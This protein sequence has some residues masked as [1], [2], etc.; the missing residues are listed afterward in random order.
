MQICDITLYVYQVVHRYVWRN[1]AI[2]H[3]QVSMHWNTAL[4]FTFNI[5]YL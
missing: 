4:Y 5:V 2:Y 1:V 3:A